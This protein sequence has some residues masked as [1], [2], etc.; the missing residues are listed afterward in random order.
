MAVRHLLITVCIATG[1]NVAAQTGGAANSIGYT[2]IGAYQKH[3]QQ[4][5]AFNA[6]QG[7]LAQYT[8][9]A[10]T[11][12]GEKRFLLDD[13]SLL[14]IGL[15]LPVQGGAFGLQASSFGSAAYSENKLGLAYGRHLGSKVALGVLFKYE[16]FTISGY[17]NRGTVSAAMGLLL[18]LSENVIAGLHVYNPTGSRLG[19]LKEAPLPQR[20]SAGLG[21][22][23]YDALYISTTIVKEMYQ[24]LSLQ[25]GLQY[26]V[27]NQL[28]VTAGVATATSAVYFGA[29][30]TKASLTIDAVAGWH[31]HLGISPGLMVTYN[32]K[33]E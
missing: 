24:P 13:L 5:L 23:P 15:V 7:A 26:R 12:Y 30:Y 31:P 10:A 32:K 20:F 9:F 3:P 33:Q 14:Q 16:H 19:R 17:G 22:T 8:T 11:A 21:Y 18:H 2:Q 29:G 6:N 25:A 27:L 1:S 4:A 28:Q